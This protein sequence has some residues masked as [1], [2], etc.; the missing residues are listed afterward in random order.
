[1][2]IYLTAIKRSVNQLTSQK[3]AEAANFF[4]RL[5]P[6]QL[7]AVLAAFIPR[8]RVSILTKKRQNQTQPR[9]LC[10]QYLI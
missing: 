1:M 3:L 10:P 8:L 7:E 5:D 9:E 6:D 4:F 2:W